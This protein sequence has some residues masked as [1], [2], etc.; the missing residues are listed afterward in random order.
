MRLSP[1]LL[2]LA[3]ISGA[4]QVLIF[5]NPS[6]TWLAWVALTPLLY[7]LLAR[8]SIQIIAATESEASAAAITT[9][10]GFW[11]GYVSGFIWYMGSC[12]WV[13]RVMHLYGGLSQPVAAGILIL[14]CLYLGLY[15]GFFG[16][17]LVRVSRRGAFAGTRALIIAPFLWVAVELAR[18][19]ITGFP[20]DLLG[21]SQVDNIPLSQLATLT[22]VYGT[23]FVIVLVNALFAAGLLVRG[24]RQKNFAVLALLLALVLQAGALIQPLPLPS[25]HVAV[26]VQ[27]NI[28]LDLQWTPQSFDSIIAKLSD[29]S[30]QASKRD[31]PSPRL[32]IWPE[33]PSPFF[34][35]DP[36]FR[37]WIST[38]AADR[39]AFILAGSLGVRNP[40]NST[41]DYETFNSAALVA[42]SGG[43]LARYD[44]IHLVPFGEYVPFQAL[45]FFAKNLTKE[46][47]TFSAGTERSVFTVNQ[48]GVSGKLGTFICYESVFPD[49]IRQFALN[50]AQVFVNVSNDGWFGSTGAAGQ[51]LNMARMRAIENHRWLLRSTNTGITA[52]IDPYG[53]VVARAEPNVQV[54]LRAP[55]AFVSDTTFY[56]R[57]GDWFAFACAIISLLTIFVRFSLRAGVIRGN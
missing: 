24:K 41:T 12:Y 49:E 48:S 3:A 55:Y 34:L 40:K 54:A 47:G 37:T 46:V 31:D 17:M 30:R 53:R 35:T 51:H 7:A 27:Q 18:A 8:P 52:S 45:L 36:K 19:R 22:G 25:T 11:V 14:F 13:Y 33:S 6:V 29:V 39:D 21:T 2:L 4:L 26:L 43:F 9:R 16:A 23:S 1:K 5:P 44:K 38:L 10:Q 28:P 56:T 32:I 20:W 50:G 15:H 42:P 57:H